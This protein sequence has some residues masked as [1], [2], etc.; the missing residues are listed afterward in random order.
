MKT[1]VVSD[2]FRKILAELDRIEA[3]APEKLPEVLV[4]LALAMITACAGRPLPSRDELFARARQ[5]LGEK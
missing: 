2:E 5:L 3:K 4:A 1:E